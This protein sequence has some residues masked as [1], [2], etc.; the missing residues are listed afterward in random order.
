MISAQLSQSIARS[1]QEL[2]IEQ[3][4]AQELAT[5]RQMDRGMPMVRLCRRLADSPARSSRQCAGPS[6]QP[7]RRA[8]LRLIA[9]CGSRR[10]RLRRSHRARIAFSQPHASRR[11]SL[12][13]Y[14]RTMYTTSR[15]PHSATGLL[16]SGEVAQR[17]TKRR[18]GLDAVADPARQQRLRARRGEARVEEEDRGPIVRMTDRAACDGQQIPQWQRRT[19]GLIDGAKGQVGVCKVSA[20]GRSQTHRAACRRPDRSWTAP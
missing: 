2:A 6:G 15:R 16:K 1:A 5:L 20:T 12:N 19:D 3:R 9:R 4:R 10:D 14:R 13:L 8:C 18:R 17:D 7:Q 11:S